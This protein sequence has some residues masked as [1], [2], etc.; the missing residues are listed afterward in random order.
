VGKWILLFLISVGLGVLGYLGGL[1]PRQA[2]T[3]S[4]FSLSILGTL[5]FWNLRLSFVFIG[6][7]VLFL[8]HSVDIE[9]FISYASLDV[10]L[11][12]IGMMIVV[13]AIKESGFFHWLVASLMRSGNLSGLQ[14]FIIIVVLSAVLSGMAGEVTSI[15]VM[16]AIIFEICDSLEVSPVPML[17]SS[18][19]TTNIGSASTLLGNPVGVLVALR[20][21]LTFEDFLTRALPVSAVA[22][23]VTILILCFRYRGYIAEVSFKLSTWNKAGQLARP[24]F[25]DFQKK[26]SIAIFSIMLLLIA[27]HKRLSGLFG[28]DENS[29]LVILPVIFAGIVML[30][31]YD[32]ALHYVENEVEWSSLLFFLFLFAQA[33]VIQSSGVAQFIAEKLVRIIGSHPRALS[34]ATLLSS[35]I[36]SGLLDNTVVVASYIPVVKNLHTMHYSL[37]P[38]WWAILFGACFGGNLTAVGSTANIVALG[39]LQKHKNIKVNFLEWLSIGVVVCA[40]SALIAYF[41]LTLL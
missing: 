17:I 20:G 19:M 4:V 31:R 39:L 7:G 2:F 18:V 3:L 6:S 14:I 38:L 27:S 35:G 40:A 37:E 21:H 1:L 30:H 26:T 36:L 41:A 29:L 12:L 28:V 11:F 16:T 5:F 9:H 24:L 8:S 25:F 34:G 15:I 23:I 10:I 13:G 22:L 33:G 32:L